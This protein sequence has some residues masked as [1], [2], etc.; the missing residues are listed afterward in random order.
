[1]RFKAPIFLIIVFSFN[2]CIYDRYDLREIIV[3][4]KSKDTLYTIV[5]PNPSVS[6]SKNFDNFEQENITHDDSIN[7][8]RFNLILPGSEG[9]SSNRPKLWDQYFDSNDEKIRLFIINKKDVNTYG[10]YEVLNNNLYNK[11]YEFTENE[12]NNNN[13]K[14]I[15]IGN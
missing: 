6:G 5:S 11:K 13:W 4:N 2:S 1:M 9:K 3:V 14:I 12:L 10:W 15:Y 7:N 8:T